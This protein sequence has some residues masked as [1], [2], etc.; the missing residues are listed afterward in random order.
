MSTTPLPLSQI[1]NVSVLVLPTNTPGPAFNQALIVGSSAVIPS[2]GANSRMRLYESLADV[3]VD[4][5]KTAPE[6]VD[7]ALYFAQGATFLWIGRQ[8][9]TAIMSATIASGGSGYTV[10][11]VVTVVQAGGALGTVRVTAIGT[12]GIATAIELASGGS[13]YAT[14][15]GLAVS[16]GG[17]T[18][19]ISVG[20]TPLMAVTACRQFNSSWFMC[21]FCGTASGAGIDEDRMAIAEYIETCSPDSRFFVTTGEASILVEGA[22]PASNIMALLQAAGYKKTF[23]LYS[24]TQGGLYPSCIHG[25]T[26]IMGLVAAH[27][28]GE[29][30][31]YFDIMFKP[32]YGIEE[33]YPGYPYYPAEPLTL[34]QVETI[35]GAVDRS[36]VGLNGNVIVL[37]QSGDVWCQN[38]VMA[39]GDWFDQGLFLSMLVNDIQTSGVAL[40]VD[41]PSVPITDG[42][43]LTLKNAVGGACQR[44]QV[45]GFIA[46]SGTWQG[47]PIGFGA[48]ALA[49]GDAM[50]KG[51]FLFVQPMS[52]WPEARRAARVLP[53]ITVAL[54][55]AQSGHSLAVTVYVQQ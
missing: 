2:V 26:A 41:S 51:Y 35:A 29:P 15:G 43:A 7:A 5:Q 27:I 12:A 21:S 4:F 53:P 32:V 49:P 14:A 54:I 44:S 16:T 11:Q 6:Y 38:G 23:S 48:G 10:G 45:L 55:M 24:T 3:A 46:P 39:S 19:N 34:K 52:T 36:Q 33:S 9:L 30:G 47:P 40:L 20:E 25:A 17:M 8:D 37:Y 22:S 28:N 31:S 18:V 50:P 42:G 13:G 1:L